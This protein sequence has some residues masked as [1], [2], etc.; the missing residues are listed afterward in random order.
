MTFAGYETSEFTHDGVCKTVY[1]KG[2]GPAVVLIHEVPGITPEAL[3]LAERLIAAGFL[4]VLPSLFGSDGKPLSNGYAAGQMLRL[5]VGKEISMLAAN[6]SS[7]ITAWLRGLCRKLHAELGGRGVG[8]I[9][10]CLTGNFVLSTMVEASVVAPV[11]AQ[12]ALPLPV[13]A[14]RAAS[15]HVSEDELVAIKSR[16]ERDDLQVLG[17][18]FSGDSKCPASRFATLREAFG[19]RFLPIEIDSS[20]GN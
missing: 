3:E 9:G 10:M 18:R 14:Q 16:A 8:V 6:A 19:S 11:L 1:R 13:G 2:R 17:L 12:P 7:P 5:C 4:V 20:P 15:L